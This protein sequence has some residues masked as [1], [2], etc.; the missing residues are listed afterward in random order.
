MFTL[1][2]STGVYSRLTAPDTKIK[3]NENNESKQGKF[4][5][6]TNTKMKCNKILNTQIG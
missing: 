4:I 2:G 6:L 3:D 1:I 5:F